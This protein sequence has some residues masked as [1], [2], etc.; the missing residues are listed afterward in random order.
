[1]IID[2]AENYSVIARRKNIPFYAARTGINFSYFQPARLSFRF[3]SQLISQSFFFRLAQILPVERV[4]C[5][6]SPLDTP[7]EALANIFWRIDSGGAGL[8]ES[9]WRKKRALVSSF[10]YFFP[11]CFSRFRLSI[12]ILHGRI[13]QIV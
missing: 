7:D 5:R 13:C 4:F 10:T 3:P 2:V 8:M 1:M 12:L 11:F 9:L 6:A